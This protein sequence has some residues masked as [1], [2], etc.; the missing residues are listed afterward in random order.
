MSYK[1]YLFD[2]LTPV[3]WSQAAWRREAEGVSTDDCEQELVCDVL[4]RHLPK[5][6]LI[7]DAGCGTAK[8][9]LYLRARG[10]RVVGIDLSHEAGARARRASPGFAF[11]RGDVRAVPLRDG[12]V[13]AVLSLGVVEHDEAGPEAALREA[14]R[15]LRPGGLLVLGVP[16]DNWAR[17]LLL[18]RLMTRATERRRASG[19][20]VGFVEYRFDDREL[21]GFL[22]QTG[23]TPIACYPNDYRPPL[24]VGLWVDHQNVT[25]NPLAPASA[26]D[27]FRLPGWKGTAAAWLVRIVPW[28]VCGE[29]T[30][31]ARAA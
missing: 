4:L 25:F 8:W 16:F 15:I 27:L 13:D 26:Q 21:R 5:D 31:V 11:V 28:L 17:R 24:N 20:R 22:A 23:F 3:E 6:G 18:N 7:V 2:A 1:V 29:I 30:Y 14:R 10:Y 9:P 12:A 19:V